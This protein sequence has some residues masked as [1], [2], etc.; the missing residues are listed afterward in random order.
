MAK[1]KNKKLRV[2]S[3]SP[4]VLSTDPPPQTF[5]EVT[6][7]FEVND[8]D[9]YEGPGMLA[10]WLNG[11]LDNGDYSEEMGYPTGVG[12]PMV[13]GIEEKDGE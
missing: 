11:T 13:I 5:I 9:A 8:N 10:E 1:K 7:R 3:I 12:M 4:P 6:L 2:V